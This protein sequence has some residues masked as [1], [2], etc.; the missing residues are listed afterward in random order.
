MRV[1]VNL[2]R[3]VIARSKSFEN[4]ITG[5]PFCG[6]SLIGCGRRF[7]EFA[8]RQIATRRPA[9]RFGMRPSVYG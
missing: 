5:L 1:S 6:T 2:I 4:Y 8:T 3:L 9:F 7:D